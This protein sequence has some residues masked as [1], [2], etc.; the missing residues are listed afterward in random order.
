MKCRE[1][2]EARALIWSVPS[3]FHPNLPERSGSYV[4][5]PSPRSLTSKVQYFL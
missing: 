5:I 4:R 3:S 1:Q 2:F